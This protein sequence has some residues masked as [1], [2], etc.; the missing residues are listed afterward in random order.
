MCHSLTLTRVGMWNKKPGA[1]QNHQ[2]HLSPSL[3]VNFLSSAVFSGKLRKLL[4]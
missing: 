2:A 1:K 3:E 4:F